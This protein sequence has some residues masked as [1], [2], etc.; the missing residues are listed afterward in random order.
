MRLALQCLALALA[1]ALAAMAARPALAGD[2]VST[3]ALDSRSAA[4]GGAGGALLDPA[5]AAFQNPAAAA[6]GGGLVVKLGYLFALPMLEMDGQ[7]AGTGSV[8]GLVLGLR[9]PILGR[10][11][12]A[13]GLRIAL[14]LG[15]HVP[16]RWLARVYLV[17]P[18]R[19]SFVMWEG[20]VNRIV[21]TPVLAISL[22]DRFS[23]G[24]GA[25]LLVDGAGS[26]DMQI[27]FEGSQARTDALLDLEL[28]VRAAPVIGVSISPTPWLALAGGYTG[29][30]GLDLD[31]DVAA[32]I[33]APGIEGT[34]VISVGGTN[35]YT[36]PS[37]WVALALRPLPF[38]GIVFQ[39]TNSFW[40]R[41]MPW[42][43]RARLEIDLGA[44]PSVVG[45]LEPEVRLHDT[46]TISAGIEGLVPVLR[47]CEVAIRG[48]YQ[49][50]QTPVPAQTGFTSYADSDV[51]LASLGL[52]FRTRPGKPVVISLGWSFQ[53]QRVVPRSVKKDPGVFIST[54][55]EAEG[56]VIATL[57]D[58]GLAF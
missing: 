46:W 49:W 22:D 4:L 54:G 11:V 37:L 32:D 20:P 24:A 19:P 16:D 6:I 14:G 13:H 15:L 10:K 45:E 36:P 29:E 43:A 2:P 56:W 28:R 18:T 47:G 21:A 12:G 30:L 17:E 50:R 5:S 35:D 39:A 34:T 53:L 33:S 48:G 40:S 23:I 58:L 7:E 26:A 38:L 55:F 52:G 25:T 51:H 8:H 42:Y 1:L 44:T 3:F 31:L 9:I 57:L 41:G 27:G